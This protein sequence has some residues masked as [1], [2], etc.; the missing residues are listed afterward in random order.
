MNWKNSEVIKHNEIARH[1]DM[2][3][4]D[5]PQFE[6]WKIFLEKKTYV[7]GMSLLYLIEW[8]ETRLKRLIK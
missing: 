8:I 3:T 1:T 5:N 7:W 6:N 4:Y 2:D